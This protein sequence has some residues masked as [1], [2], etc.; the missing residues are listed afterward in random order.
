MRSPARRTL[1]N[2]GA[3]RAADGERESG[4][5]LPGGQIVANGLAG[6]VAQRPGQDVA[7]PRDRDPMW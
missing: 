7:L 1:A 5:A 6:R 3:E 2:T 4:G